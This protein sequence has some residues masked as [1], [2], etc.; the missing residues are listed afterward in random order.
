[1]D[2]KIIEKIKVKAEDMGK[3]RFPTTIK[4][5]QN[6]EDVKLVLEVI[7]EELNKKKNKE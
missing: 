3:I 5:I 2:K 1:M 6:I 7:L 4:A